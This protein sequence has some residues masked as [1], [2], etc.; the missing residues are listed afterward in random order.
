MTDAFVQ[1]GDVSLTKD[2]LA[3]STPAWSE[4]FAIEFDVIV[5]SEL[6]ES[7]YNIFHMTTGS[8]YNTLGARIPAVWANHLKHFHIC[9]DVNGD[10][11]YCKKY[12]Y[13]LDKL[14]HIE[15]S[16]KKNSNDEALYNI[17]VDGTTFHEVINTMPQ[18]FQ[19]AKLYLSDPW[20]PSLAPHGTLSNLS[21]INGGTH[22]NK[23]TPYSL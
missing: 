7:W 13:N 22:Q 21:I 20:H 1:L 16:Q 19:N 6:T 17:R 3:W 18:I 10:N 11:D 5:N 15:I 2:N 23:R 4:E 12:N 8:N 9:F 14:Y